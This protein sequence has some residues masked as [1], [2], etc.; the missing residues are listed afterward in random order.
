MRCE[1]EPIPGPYPEVEPYDCGLLDVG[2]GNSL[3]WEACG[4]PAGKAAVVLHGGPG[5]G[6]TAWHRQLFDPD[7][8]RIVLYDQRNCGRLFHS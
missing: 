5:S 3:Y 4:N 6:C 8:Y 1:D 2:D 7:R